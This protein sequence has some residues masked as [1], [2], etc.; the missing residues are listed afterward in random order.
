MKFW[1][2]AS[3]ANK[4]S[5]CPFVSS[6]LRGKPFWFSVPLCLC[7]ETFY[8]QFRDELF[9]KAL[10]RVNSQLASYE[11]IKKFVILPGEFSIDSGELTPSLKVKRKYVSGK[12]SAELDSMY[13]SGAQLD[14]RAGNEIGKT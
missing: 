9:E 12:F 13:S 8:L 5:S 7:G 2:R 3:R 14:N 11:T 10:D 6:R 4:S 1:L